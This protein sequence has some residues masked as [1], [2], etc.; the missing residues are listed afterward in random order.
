MTQR[1]HRRTCC[2][3]FAV[4]PWTCFV[5]CVARATTIAAACTRRVAMHIPLTISFTAISNSEPNTIL[6]FNHGAWCHV[7]C[8]MNNP[9]LVGES[10]MPNSL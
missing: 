3:D 4:R 2:E 9:Q 5:A 1:P 8:W 7:I 10:A 6:N